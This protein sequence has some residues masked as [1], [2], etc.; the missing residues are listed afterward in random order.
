MLALDLGQHTGWALAIRAAH[1]LGHREHF[2]A[3]RFEGGGMP[4]PALQ[5]LAHEV[6]TRPD[7]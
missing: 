7:R 3:H 1:H 4:L 2:K 5:A 6:C